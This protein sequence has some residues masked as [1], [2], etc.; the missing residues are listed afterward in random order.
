MRP[1]FRSLSQDC[2]HCEDISAT[3]TVELKVEDAWGHSDTC[4]T[5]VQVVDKVPPV[6]SC[7]GGDTTTD[8]DGSNW[9]FDI[10]DA[11]IV[12]SNYV[13]ACD[14]NPDIEFDTTSWGCSDVGDTDTLTVTVS[15]QW[16][17]QAFCTREVFVANTDISTT[18]WT[19]VGPSNVVGEGSGNSR[20]NPWQLY[21]T[22]DSNTNEVTLS[23]GDLYD[24]A[25]TSST[26]C[27]GERFPYSLDIKVGNGPTVN[28]GSLGNS[29]LD[30][31][32]MPHWG[33][34]EL[35]RHVIEVTPVSRDG[36]R[37]STCSQEINVNDN[38]R[39]SVT[40]NTAGDITWIDPDTE[41][42]STVSV[43]TGS[44]AVAA[45]A[46]C[47]NFAN[48]PTYS[49]VWRGTENPGG[50]FAPSTAQPWYDLYFCCPSPW[51]CCG[52]PCPGGMEV[53][54]SST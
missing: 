32:D 7:V 49:G 41:C 47:R 34:G 14:P 51:A 9:S 33:C 19:C 29:G 15:D 17:N 42:G 28:S 26:P 50:N 35:G 36:R 11:D 31:S 46:N 48:N 13:D 24:T 53:G 1:T 44:A 2:F 5:T 37:G 38:V 40:C 20:S 3:P 12:L 39:R 10:D 52:G 4:T 27:S 45:Q 23:W 18:A 16:D 30:R 22:G 8:L 25:I 54:T 6:L 43:S 21:I